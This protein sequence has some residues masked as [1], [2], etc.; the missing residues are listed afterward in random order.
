MLAKG[1]EKAAA[2]S[3]HRLGRRAGHHNPAT[4][5]KTHPNATVLIDRALADLVGYGC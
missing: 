5:I 3:R 2:H 4:M 1:A